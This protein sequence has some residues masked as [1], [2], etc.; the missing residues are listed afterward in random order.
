V[1]SIHSTRKEKKN[2]NRSGT[3]SVTVQA[4]QKAGNLLTTRET[5]NFSKT[6][7]P[8]VS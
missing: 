2:V 6:L 8:A 4:Q 5:I 7:L 1:I 3:K